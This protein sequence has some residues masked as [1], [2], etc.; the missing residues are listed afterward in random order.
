MLNSYIT[1]IVIAI[2]K[3]NFE[4]RDEWIICVKNFH[5]FE[6]SISNIRK[7][8]YYDALFN[9]RLSSIKTIE[10]L[11]RKVQEDNPELRGKYWELRQLQ[12]GAMKKEFLMKIDGQLGL[13]DDFDEE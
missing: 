5:D 7:E 1:R 10:R 4:A 6:M 2:L 9:K 8:D 12:G 11:W 3:K 13:F